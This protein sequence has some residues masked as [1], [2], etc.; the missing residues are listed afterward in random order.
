M[1]TRIGID[2]TTVPR[3]FLVRPTIT[4]A[5][6]W[7]VDAAHDGGN[8]LPQ[9]CSCSIRGASKFTFITCIRVM[10]AVD[11]DF[12]VER[13]GISRNLSKIQSIGNSPHHTRVLVFF[14]KALSCFLVLLVESF[15]QI[16][17]I[18]E[19]VGEA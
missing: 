7:G 14:R 8:W 19:Q 18:L 11:C 1:S 4:F 3:R 9:V 10:M 15:R 16:S 17:R 5:P 13:C 2:F 12:F 6:L